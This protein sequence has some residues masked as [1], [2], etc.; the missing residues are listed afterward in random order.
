[1]ALGKTQMSVIAVVAVVAGYY[2]W[3]KNQNSGVPTGSE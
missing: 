3:K 2:M 1:M